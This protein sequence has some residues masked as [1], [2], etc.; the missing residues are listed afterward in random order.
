M[1]YLM[2]NNGGCDPF[3]Y[4]RGK[5]GLGYKPSPPFMHGLGYDYNLID[6]MGIK[7]GTFNRDYNEVQ[8]L[9]E[10]DPEEENEEQIR[11]L[12]INDY[13][14][15]KEENIDITKNN[16]DIDINDVN[17]EISDIEDWITI[18]N[19]YKNA[20]L[21]DSMDPKNFEV[22]IRAFNLE[23][24]IL[25]KLKS[26]K[27]EVLEENESL[28]TKEQLA[29][30]F[31][32]ERLKT[33]SFKGVKNEL[34][35]MKI[36]EEKA[37]NFRKN[38]I[39][40][41]SQEFID[42]MRGDVLNEKFNIHKGKNF[43]NMLKQRYN[44]NE[45]NGTG[46]ETVQNQPEAKAEIVNY[47]GDHSNIESQARL[48][49]NKIM[50]NN[51]IA[52]QWINTGENPLEM[53]P[54]D[55]ENDY[56][57]IEK[58]NYITTDQYQGRKIDLQFYKEIDKLKRKGLTAEEI[59]K[60]FIDKGIDIPTVLITKGKLTGL[61]SNGK[62]AD[63]YHHFSEDP[64]TGEKYMDS[65]IWNK[66][67]PGINDK[68]EISLVN[69]PKDYKIWDGRKGF[70]YDLLL[71][72]ARIIYDP[73][74]DNNM[75]LTNKGTIRVKNNRYKTTEGNLDKKLYYEVPLTRVIIKKN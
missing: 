45:P 36:K 68:G 51:I 6:G 69:A 59:E 12:L 10:L 11:D 70:I 37:K 66:F 9:A 15:I 73:L 56:Y 41:E 24:S 18:F 19:N 60:N 44:I 4:I 65:I 22:N 33:S 72:N 47:T 54:S 74:K 52:Q 5:G 21:F 26:F 2:I 58:K 71:D 61:K 75:E 32:D 31:Y 17:K 38:K 49:R 63:V 3:H 7:G 42:E 62:K 34:D 53:L 64:N 20:N 29:K 16:F 14:V 35:E 48:L 50:P 43:Y 13:D 8:E 46:W 30:E 57:K 67:I 40:D 27:Q 25:P 23:N 1:D 28:K 55:S 39:L